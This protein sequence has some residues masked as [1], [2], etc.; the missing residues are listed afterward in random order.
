[1]GLPDY[2][3]GGD[4]ILPDEYGDDAGGARRKGIAYAYAATGSYTR[5]YRYPYGN[6]GT[7]AGSLSD[8][9]SRTHSQAYACRYRR[10]RQRL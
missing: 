1:M 5:G 6:T 4:D 9:Y 8:T 2:C 3:G 7:H 10:A